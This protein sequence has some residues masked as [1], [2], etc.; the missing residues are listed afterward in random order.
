MGRHRLGKGGGGPRLFGGRPRNAALLVSA[1]VLG[2]WLGVSAP[3]VS[4]VAPPLPATP[5][6]RV[7]AQSRATVSFD[8]W[9]VA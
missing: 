7:P 4:P 9:W 1:S 2:L 3:D 8:A 6:A 5:V